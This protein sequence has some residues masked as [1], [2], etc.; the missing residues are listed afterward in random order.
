MPEDENGLQNGFDR[1]LLNWYTIDPIFYSNQRPGEI[2][3]DDVSD[4]Y[5]RRIFID[6]VFPEIDI[7]QGQ[8]TIINSLDLAYYPTERGP[9][10]FD[11]N[12]TDGVI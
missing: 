3:D 2:T 8:Q 9:Y 4:L 6:E 1:A 7:A 5:T 10:N 12:A 11:P